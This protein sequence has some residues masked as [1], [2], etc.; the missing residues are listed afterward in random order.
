MRRKTS[1]TTHLI[2]HSKK[3]TTN[4]LLFEII[5]LKFIRVESNCTN[6]FFNQGTS[7]FRLI[8]KKKFTR[9]QFQ[10]VNS[11]QQSKNKFRV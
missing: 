6:V 3:I 1:H 8:M 7:C 9:N 2:P 4:K 5:F 10:N 11:T